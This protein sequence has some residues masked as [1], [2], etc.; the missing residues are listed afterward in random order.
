VEYIKPILTNN[1]PRHFPSV[2][3]VYSFHIL[4]VTV[5]FSSW[6]RE[7][8]D[9]ILVLWCYYCKFVESLLLKLHF[10]TTCCH[11]HHSIMLTYLWIFLVELSWAEPSHLELFA[12]LGNLSQ[13][14][15]YYHSH[16]YMWTFLEN[17]KLYKET[18]FKN[19]EI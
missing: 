14:A 8:V 13:N 17:E 4:T 7:N 18:Y 11:C 16:T 10:T 15:S 19:G 5:C 1:Q 12:F 9:K 2:C 3:R 6:I